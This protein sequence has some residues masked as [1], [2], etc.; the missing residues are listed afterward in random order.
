M[1]FTG[2]H[3]KIEEIIESVASN[4][5]YLIYESSVYLKGNNSRITIKIDRQQ[6]ITHLDCDIFS[7]EIAKRLDKED[8]LANYSME[9]SSPGLSRKLRTLDEFIRF[10]NSQVKVIFDEDGE[11]KVIKGILNNIIDTNIELKSDNN[12]II[13]I[14]YKNIVKANLEY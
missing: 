6:G 4:L 9:V 2:T 1:D 5:N 14:E 7:K 12:E 11:R 8:L 3:E 10:K 13:I